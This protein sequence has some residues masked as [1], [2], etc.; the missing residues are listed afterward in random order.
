M[1]AFF[2][3]H[4]FISH[5]LCLILFFLDLTWMVLKSFPPN[6]YVVVIFFAFLFPSTF[7]FSI[8]PFLI[9]SSSRSFLSFH[10]SVFLYSLLFLLTSAI[11]LSFFFERK[12]EHH[13]VL[14]Q[15]SAVNVSICTPCSLGTEAYL[16]QVLLLIPK[17]NGWDPKHAM[18]GNRKPVKILKALD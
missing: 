18:H 13:Y 16:L 2:A 7:L 9:L 3:A 17:S 1:V 8:Y 6:L 4:L 10:S 11:L 12:Y 14:L 5:F 15:S